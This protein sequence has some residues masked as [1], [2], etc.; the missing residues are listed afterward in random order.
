MAE[1][2]LTSA[3]RAHQAGD[4]ARAA[5]LYGEILRLEPR[6]FMAL[7]GLGILHYQSGQWEECERVMGLAIRAN[8]SSGDCF[9]TR[10]CALQRLGRP[11]EALIC[12][13]QVIAFNPGHGDAHS[14]RGVALMTMN[15]L[16]EAL[17]SFTSALNIDGSN[18]AVW[19]NRGCVLVNLGR[20]GEAIPCFDNAIARQGGFA[21]AFVNRA[22]AHAA[23]KHYPAA[24]ADFERT[25]E[26][27]P[28][29]PY[30]TGHLAHY[31]MQA[32]DWRHFA[33]DTA[34]IAEGIRAGKRVVLPFIHLA[35][36]DSPAGQ[37]RCASIWTENDAPPRPN[38]LWR[39]EIYRHDRIRLAYVS[40]DFHAH[41]TAALMAEIFE[42]HDRRQ[43][44][45]TAISFGPD[46]ATPMRA[47]VQ[48]AFD[49]FID[50][51]N[52]SDLEIA[53]LIRRL[54]IDIAVD[55][56]GLTKDNRAGIFAHRPA[57]VQVSY[58]GY[59]GTMAAP[60][61]D[62]LLADR[63]VVPEEQRAFYRERVVYLP[64]SYQ[65]NTA[66]PISANA[67]TRADFGLPDQ[68]FVFCC[69][70]NSYKITPDVFAV[71]MRL[72]RAVRG[73]TLWLLEDN[74]GMRENLRREAE[75]R[76]IASGRLVFAPRAAMDEHLA[77]HRHADLFLDTQP[78]GA[79]TTAS[80]ALWAGVPVLTVEGATFP[81]RVAASLLRAAR[82][83]E[84]ITPD[85]AE[86]EAA[87]LRLAWEPG[88]LG[89]IRT[90]LAATR[91]Q[92]PLFDCERFTRHLESAFLSM[93][94]RSRRG[95]TPESFS[96]T[97][98]AQ[99]GPGAMPIPGNAAAAYLEGCRLIREQNFSAALARFDEAVALAPEFIEALTNRGGVLMAL[100]RPDEA[101]R[102]LD[103]A[104]ALNPNMPE[105]WNN[106]G[107]A[108]SVLGRHD[109]AVQSFDR[110]L[111]LRP[112]LIEALINRG[113][114]LLTLRRTEDAFASYEAALK[115]DPRNSAA[116][117]GRANALFELKRFEEAA[118][119]FEVA[120]AAGPGSDFAGKLAFTR[121]QCCDWRMLDQD[122]AALAGTGLSQYSRTV[123]PFQ[124][125]AISASPED[126]RRCAEV[127]VGAK[128][129]AKPNPLWT[130]E[131]YQHERVRVAW[132]SADYRV[133]PVAQ[134]L[135]GVL[136]RLD[137]SQIESIGVGWGIADDSSVREK[138]LA[139]FDSFVSADRLTDAEVAKLLREREIDVAVDLMGFTAESRPGILAARPAP[140]QVSYLGF[141]GTMG[142]PYI[143]HL[144]ADEIA[145]PGSEVAHFSEHILRLT[146]SYFPV[147]NGRVIGPAPP[148]AA[149]GLPDQG[150]IFACFNNSYKLTPEIF[151]IWMR[152]LQQIDGSVLWL[153]PAN[154]AAMRNLR[155]EAEIRKTD[156][157][158]LIFARYVQ[159][160][161]HH[162]ARLGAADLF[163]DTLPYNAHATAADAL[164]AGLPVITCKGTTF[165]GRV[166]A[167]LL[168]AAGLPELVSDDLAG[169]E[170]LALTFARDSEMLRACKQKL[171][172][173]RPTQPLFDTAAYADKL[174]ELLVS[175]R[176]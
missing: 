80:D 82:L 143:D 91:A 50:V 36:S 158:R 83:P 48:R 102:S 168:H 30:V 172:A 16:D 114:A 59:P 24:I 23:L 131:E 96:V 15:R 81:G 98:E 137:R 55:L 92:M 18:A 112:Q 166:A 33:E 93:T 56:K 53:T 79:H 19:N 37:F 163:L 32:C 54:E 63:T 67:G 151:E 34:R 86:Y 147:D 164:L 5:R 49:R 146:G 4:V 38:P 64:D 20:H 109:E 97:G 22:S 145:I 119:G 52:A 149:A 170:Q 113:T 76:G 132:L 45:T 14:N 25:V 103:L 108:L 47:R 89:G 100:N 105:A 110:V 101:I 57:P 153:S 10:G 62:Y 66:R 156:P 122:R 46:D 21:Q 88:T 75:T 11:A 127:W 71:W 118:S 99:S 43:F 160:P 174:S 107:N 148:R 27:N 171:A 68:G 126:Q 123:D 152:L 29:F 128:H 104:L 162:L 6:Q 28:D 95:E 12:F 3:V 133:H 7:Q 169:Y 142:A 125:L 124:Y 138:V 135:A 154:P 65:A 159:E 144:I 117:H 85:L 35:L 73:S 173:A 44:E 106:R 84:L 167:S 157:E 41:A 13:D 39:G 120:M 60:Y 175:L 61:I 42:R 129:P 87:A 70:N 134:A 26:I 17:E 40:A 130:G 1:P 31:R 155:R 69:F 116:L 78:Y 150:F 51:R 2:L 111:A 176:R 58:L 9:F 121:L 161:E 139:G 136:P 94:E 77:R 74:A 72:L 8:P 115:G 90:K 165:A 140:V 141:A